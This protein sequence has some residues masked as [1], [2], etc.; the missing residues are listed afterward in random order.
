MPTNSFDAQLCLGLGQHAVHAGMAGRT[1][2][3]VGVW[4]QRFTHVPIPVAVAARRLLDPRGELWH[5]VLE[6]TGQER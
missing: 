2:V 1:D 5:G 3:L 4:N 6:S